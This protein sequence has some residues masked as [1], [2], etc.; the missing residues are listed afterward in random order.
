MENTAQIQ[1]EEVER[2]KKVRKNLLWLG[3]VSIVML[4]A[5]LTSALVVR[6]GKGD[7]VPIQIPF[8]F[9]LSTAVIIVSSITFNWAISAVKSGK[10]ANANK[11]MLITLIL[12]VIFVF[13]QFAGYKSLVQQGVYFTGGN[14]SG[15]F[16]YMLTFMHL[17]HLLG[18]IFSVLVVYVKTI[19]NKYTATNYLGMHLSA[20]YW[21]FLD[22]LWVYLFLFLYVIG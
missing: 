3:I 5:G 10:G 17:L 16:F 15:S 6:Q 13:T 20:I 9:Y 19:Q 1:S 7:W 21:H 11:A 22:F 18:G 12:G 4:F 14:A 2:N 8:M